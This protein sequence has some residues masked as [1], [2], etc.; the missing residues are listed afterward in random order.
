MA[1]WFF[2]S[3]EDARALS[4]RD[5]PDALVDWA[6]ELGARVVLLKL[7]AEGVVVSDGTTREHLA[8][9]MA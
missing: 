5:E 9:R 4:G 2:P 8:R 7:G 6:H 1:D 3:L